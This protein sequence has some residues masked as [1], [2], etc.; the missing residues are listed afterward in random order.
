MKYLKRKNGITLIAL[1]ITVIIMLILVA[2]TIQVATEGNLFKHA[3]NAV[4]ETKNAI[5]EEN[6]ILERT[7]KSRWSSIQ[8][9][10]RIHFNSYNK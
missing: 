6:Y 2:V 4:K 5:L 7:N 1:I 8:F 10:R 9:N 3:G